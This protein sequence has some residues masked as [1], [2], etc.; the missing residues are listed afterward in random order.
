MRTKTVME[1]SNVV[2]NDEV[3]SEAHSE[4][5]APVQDKPMEVDDSLP[6]D[7][8]RKHSDEELM[9]LNDA[10]SMPSSPEPSTP[11]HET[12][13]AQHGFSLSSEQ[14]GTSTSLVKGPSSRVRLNHP[15]INILG[16][17]N[18]NM[19]LRS[20]ALSVITHSCYLCQFE[21]RKVDKALQGAD[22]IN[23]MHEELHQFVWNDVWEL[24][25]RPKGVNVIGTKWIFKNKSDEHGTVIRN[26]SR[27]VA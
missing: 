19:R 11:V 18:D 3:C 22:W 5:T 13:Q 14:K 10:V 21:L 8:V 23:S 1:S 25:P 16:S 27:L 6:I 24:F 9:V 15:S 7:Y 2:I 12:Q 26:K 4:N 20:K 17:L